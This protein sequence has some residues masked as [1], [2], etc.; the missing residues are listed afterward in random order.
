MSNKPLKILI[1]AV[2]MA[3][4]AGCTSAPPPEP[5]KQEPPPPQNLLG[6]TDELQLVTELTIDLAKQ[7]GGERILVA[8]EVDG[9][10]LAPGPDLD[11]G[12]R[13][14]LDDAGPCSPLLAESFAKPVLQPVQAN[15]ADQ[16]QRMQDAGLRVI[17]FSQRGPDCLSSTLAQLDGNGISFRGSAWTLADGAAGSYRPAGADRPVLY[18]D[19][20]FLGDGQDKGLMLKALLERSGSPFPVLIVL[21]DQSQDNLNAVMKEFSWTSTKVHAWRYTRAAGDA[22]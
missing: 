3:A 2:A 22:Y 8:L 4:F 5:E 7:Y 6:S 1:L 21:V 15:A 19:G 10:L 20:V 12:Q 9:T 13:A 11:A 16:V 14:A 17:A 18:R